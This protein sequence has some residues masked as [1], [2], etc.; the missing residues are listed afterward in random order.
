MKNHKYPEYSFVTETG[1]MSIDFNKTDP[2]FICV[3]CYDGTVLV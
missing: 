2:F 3:G 1:V